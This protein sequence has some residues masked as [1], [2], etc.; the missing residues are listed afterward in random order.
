[1]EEFY[2]VIK[3]KFNGRFEID[4]P[5]H[6]NEYTFLPIIIIKD[7]LD[8]LRYKFQPQSASTDYTNFLLNELNRIVVEKREETINYILNK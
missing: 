1:M 3:E 2:F 4:R 6:Y 5:V 7:N 8:N